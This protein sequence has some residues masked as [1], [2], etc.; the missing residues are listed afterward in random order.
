MGNRQSEMKKKWVHVRIA[1]TTIAKLDKVAQQ[2]GKTRQQLVDEA[3]D[4]FFK[5]KNF[6]HKVLS[7]LVRK[8]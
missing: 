2:L 1:D 8:P 4:R 6:Q 7:A 3:F 5:D